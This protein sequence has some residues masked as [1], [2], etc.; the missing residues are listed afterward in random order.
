MPKKRSSQ[1]P[2]LP[3]NRVRESFQPGLELSE[4]GYREMFERTPAAKCLIDVETGAIVD[5]NRAACEFYGYSREEML[6][7]RIWDITLADEE[8]IRT[9]MSAVSEGRASRLSWK[10]K[11]STGGV[12]DVQV[13]TTT[14]SIAGRTLLYSVI[15]PV[16]NGTAEESLRDAE[17]YRDIFQHASVGIYQVSPSGKLL[18]AN[19]TIARLLG[20]DS[21]Q[22]LATLD[23]RHLYYHPEDREV[24]EQRSASGEDVA[25]LE[26][27][28][29][30]K[31]GE[32]VWVQLN[33]QAVRDPSGETAY[34]EGFVH[35]IT[36]RKRAEGILKRQAI[37]FDTSTDG[38]AIIDDA[39]NFVY[40]NEAHARLYAYENSKDLIGQPWSTL[41]NS[42]EEGRFRN[43][44]F[45]LMLRRGDWRGEGEGRR[46]GGSR[47]PQEISV[48]ALE[49]GGFV[50]VVRDI[51]ER[52][53][54][55]EQIR[56]LAYHDALTRLPNRL[57]FEDR[58]SLALALA[59]REKSHVGVLFLDL[60]GFKLINDSLGHSLAD[61]LLQSV[62]RRI[63]GS[64]RETDTVSRFGGDEFTILLPLINRNEDAAFTA[65]KILDALREPFIIGGQELFVTASIGVSV[66]PA[67]GTLAEELIKNADAAMY[68]AKDLGRDNVQIFSDVVR[69]SPIERLT[70][71]TSL[72]RAV[73]THELVVHYQPILD[74]TDGRV[75][76]LEALLRWQHPSLG[77]VFPTGFIPIAEAAGLMGTIGPWVTQAALNQLHDW[78]AAGHQRMSVAINLAVSQI[79]QG[80][81]APVMVEVMKRCD[82]PPE[83]VEVEITESA[84]MQYPEMAIRS[85]QQ[86]RDLG[87]KVSLD[88]FGTGYSSLSYLTQFPIDTLKIDRSFVRDLDSRTR[89]SVPIVT[90]IMAMSRALGLEV[91]AEGVEREEEKEILLQQ[92]CHLMQGHLFSPAVPPEALEP[93]LAFGKFENGP[94][95]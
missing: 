44:I 71:E 25:D 26:Q 15:T 90:A 78:R 9:N 83:A 22:E 14:L 45:P 34:F 95:G 79:Q 47:F 74:A 91:I 75:V 72:R 36:E 65:R 30:K 80:D 57:L 92:G 48:T 50:L 40:M 21:A 4:H 49:E 62:S 89:S 61:S 66:S 76:S 52:R 12:Q 11:T 19:D 53:K 28:W 93:F 64:L 20:Y 29:K 46:R 1:E 24:L 69:A 55:E 67:D 38:I 88:D 39:G 5:A 51:S 59:E 6:T 2:P 37:A 77:L 23:I 3:E 43:E 35:D 70:L 63:D 42:Y 8:A 13:Y 58:L 60:D 87:V 94:R 18:T 81:L 85:L 68:Y 33:A 86:L 17:K 84:A 7:K 32:P 16:A 82:V 27:L 54:A 56:H 41:Y 31:N 10:Q 73:S